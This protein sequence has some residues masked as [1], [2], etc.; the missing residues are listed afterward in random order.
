MGSIIDTIQGCSNPE[1]TNERITEVSL[2]SRKFKS[3]RKVSHNTMTHSSNLIIT[4]FNTGRKIQIKVYKSAAKVLKLVNSG[5]VWATEDNTLKVE[6]VDG[7]HKQYFYIKCHT[8]IS[9][10]NWVNS[11]RV[12]KRPLWVNS[13]KCGS[14]HK[15]FNIVAVKHHCRN[16][17]KVLN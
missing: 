12:A 9:F 14:C 4:A 2:L 15:D 17:G 16:C 8:K 11:I 3:K 6:V 7:R 10:F 1:D 13:N 5:N